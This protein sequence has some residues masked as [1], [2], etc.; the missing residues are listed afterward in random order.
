MFRF[1]P[2]LMAMIYLAAP[3]AAQE[4]GA[5]RNNTVTARQ[6]TQAEKKQEKVDKAQ[7]PTNVSNQ[8]ATD[9]KLRVTTD[10]EGSRRN[11]TDDR[12]SGSSNNGSVYNGGGSGSSSANNKNG[13]NSGNNNKPATGGNYGGNSGYNNRPVNGGNN[14]NTPPPPPPAH[15]S[16][17][18]G[19]YHSGSYIPGYADMYPGTRPPIPTVRTYSRYET[20]ERTNAAGIV[21]NTLFTSKMEAYDYIARLLRARY[22]SVASYGNNYDWIRSEVSFIPTPFDWTNPMTHNQFAMYFKITR[23]FGRVKVTITAQW[24]ESVLSDRFSTLRFQPSNTYSTYYAWNVLEDIAANLPNT[25]I[26]YRTA[27]L[28]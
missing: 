9:V 1:L 13:Y 3:A 17:Y 25:G 6:E 14:H 15:N 23:V 26:S 27:D 2:A 4:G 12:N 11:G 5:R 24:R 19:G 16:G 22:Y 7:Y 10:R 18:N 8:A 21:V 28:L 20:Y